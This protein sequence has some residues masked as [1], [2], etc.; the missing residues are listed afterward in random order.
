MNPLVVIYET[1]HANENLHK[2]IRSLEMNNYEYV[3]IGKNVKWEGFGTKI[4]G[5]NDYYKKCQIKK[6]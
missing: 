1:N 6:D 3:V 4:N 5:C 2:L